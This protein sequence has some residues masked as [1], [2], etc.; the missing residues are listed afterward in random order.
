MGTD[1]HQ[2]MH[3]AA[4]L[5]LL[6]LFAHVHATELANI[7]IADLKELMV[8]RAVDKNLFQHADDVIAIPFAQGWTAALAR[9][10]GIKRMQLETRRLAA[11][12]PRR[13][14]R[15]IHSA[16][17]MLLMGIG[18]LVAFRFCH[19]VSTTDEE[20]LLPNMAGM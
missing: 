19:G 18:T 2:K 20:P 12:S 3:S 6:A 5:T 8:D 16:A 17:V 4:A 13:S 10:K 1:R 15:C 11:V 14:L 7:H 9:G